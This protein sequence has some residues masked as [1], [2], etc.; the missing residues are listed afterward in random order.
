MTGHVAEVLLEGRIS[1]HDQVE[2]G[3]ADGLAEMVEDNFGLNVYV[4]DQHKEFD[5]LAVDLM[6]SG[7]SDAVEE[8]RIWLENRD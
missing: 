8:A 7:S 5:Y 4:F 6:C 2:G 1:F 3:N